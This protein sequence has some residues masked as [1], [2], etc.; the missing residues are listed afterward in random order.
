MSGFAKR[1]SSPN[2]RLRRV[3]YH[4]FLVLLLRQ[5]RSWLL[6][7]TNKNAAD[8]EFGRTYATE[9]ENAA[10]ANNC[11]KARK[12]TLGSYNE[13]KDKTTDTS[14]GCCPGQTGHHIIPN[15]AVK[16][17]GCDDYSYGG[18]PVICLEGVNN[19]WGSHGEAHENL[20]T[21]MS[22]YC[23]DNKTDTILYNEMRNLCLE[24]IKH[25]ATH[26][27]KKCLQEQ[28]DEKYK[29]GDK[30]LAAKSGQGGGKKGAKSNASR[31]FRAR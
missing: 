13:S 18:T 8:A 15:S 19:S 10:K 26:C 21:K 2:R 28:L 25:D 5:P 11:V 27:N 7:P 17:A 6:L 31:D 30:P 16:D 29:C 20:G 23:K 1:H 24:A 22:D 3:G 4:P 12:C 9:T 14:A